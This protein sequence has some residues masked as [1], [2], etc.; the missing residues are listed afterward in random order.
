MLYLCTATRFLQHHETH[1]P[2]SDLQLSGNR[3]PFDARPPHFRR[4]NAQ[5]M[6][7]ADKN[8]RNTPRN[9]NLINTHTM[10]IHYDIHTIE[11]AQG[12]GQERKFVRLHENE[13]MSEERLYRLVEERCTLTQSDLKAAVSALRR[14]MGEELAAGHRFTLPG[15]GYFSLQA[16]LN[17]QDAASG[18]VS[19]NDLYVRNVKFLPTRSLLR[20]VQSSTRFERSDGTSRSTRYTEEALMQRIQEY[21]T[22]HPCLTRLTLEREF[23]IRKT[24]ANKWLARLVAHGRL[25]KA[26]SS[27]CP[28][29]FLKA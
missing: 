25:S 8:I 29:Y 2:V 18:K 19:G 3:P 10:A 21:L 7:D 13:P 9:I 20:E 15:I 1:R 6:T 28:V 23:N 16:G 14:M 26:G 17:K 4:A 11:N 12:T 22:T 24:T 5:H 27:S